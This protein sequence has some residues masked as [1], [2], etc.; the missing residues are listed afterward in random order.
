MKLI[1]G[2]L[3]TAVLVSGCSNTSGNN[4]DE[5]NQAKS[6]ACKSIMRDGTGGVQYAA[7]ALFNNSQIQLFDKLAKLDEKYFEISLAV[8]YAY[9]LQNRENLSVP[10][11]ETELLAIEYKKQTAKIAAFCG[12]L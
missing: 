8:H 5:I 9:L 12:A 11:N 4:L 6:D 10:I 3:I 1:A 2:A 7:L